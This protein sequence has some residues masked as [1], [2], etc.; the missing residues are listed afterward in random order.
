MVAGGSRPSI[1]AEASLLS[2]RVFS[3]FDLWK[4]PINGEARDEAIKKI[5]RYFSLSSRKPGNKRTESQVINAR[6]V[7][8]VASKD[9]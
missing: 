1:L 7:R 2:G 5:K 4:G 3:F 6:L 8:L 9:S